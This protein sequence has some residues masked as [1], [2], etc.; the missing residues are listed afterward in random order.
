M[1]RL[2]QPGLISSY[3]L[4]LISLLGWDFGTTALLNI[5][6]IDSAVLEQPAPFSMVPDCEALQA[7]VNA[8]LAQFIAAA[9]V[10]ATTD[11]EEEDGPGG[12]LERLLKN[13]ASVALKPIASTAEIDDE[14]YCTFP[15]NTVCTRSQKPLL[16]AQ[17]FECV[18]LEWMRQ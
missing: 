2:S 13:C 12:V 10:N 4:S 17:N 15:D 3:D 6:Q 16:P 1:Q 5:L 18:G 14:L 8:T 7:S 11:E 9:G